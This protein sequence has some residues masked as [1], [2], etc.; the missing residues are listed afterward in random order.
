MVRMVCLSKFFIS[1]ANRITEWLGTN[2]M[3]TNGVSIEL[4]VC[5][6]ASR[7]FTACHSPALPPHISFLSLLLLSHEGNM[8]KKVIVKKKE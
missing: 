8:P 6:P 1:W 3:S 2:L 5:F 7:T 4:L